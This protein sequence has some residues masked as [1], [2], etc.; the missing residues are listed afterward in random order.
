[1][2]ICI[3]DPGNFCD[4]S[5]KNNYFLWDNNMCIETASSSCR[6]HLLQCIL[7]FPVLTAAGRKVAHY[8]V[9]NRVTRSLFPLCF[10]RVKK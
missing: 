1:M 4:Q 8:E 2:T 10:P 9:V 7:T 6:F 3:W 5:K